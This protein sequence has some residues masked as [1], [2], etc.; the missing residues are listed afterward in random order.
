MNK[1]TTLRSLNSIKAF[2]LGQLEGQL[3]RNF[4]RITGCI[5]RAD[6]LIDS[7]NHFD[8]SK[9]LLANYEP[10]TKHSTNAEFIADY[11]CVI[12]WMSHIYAQMAEPSAAMRDVLKRFY[13]EDEIAYFEE[14]W[15]YYAF[16]YEYLYNK[17][18]NDRTISDT[19]KS[20]VYRLND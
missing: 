8:F 10:I 16:A 11:L 3:I 4:G 7:F 5:G 12:N 14:C 17:F 1:H 19:V 13:L 9:K 2:Y 15:D 6:N 18:M 20:S